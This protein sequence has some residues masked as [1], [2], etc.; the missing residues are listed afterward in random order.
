MRVVVVDWWFVRRVV[1][2][3]D[4]SFSVDGRSWDWSWWVVVLRVERADE[5]GGD[6]CFVRDLEGLDGVDVDADV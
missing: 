6:C 2:D 3:V 1:R 4:V 5:R